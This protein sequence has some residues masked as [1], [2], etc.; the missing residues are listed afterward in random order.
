[1]LVYIEQI[2]LNLPEDESCCGSS[3][4][5][6]AWRLDLLSFSLPTTLPE[7]LTRA[8]TFMKESS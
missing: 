7:T 5:E 6:K 2:Y 1:M 4:P 8:S 3:D